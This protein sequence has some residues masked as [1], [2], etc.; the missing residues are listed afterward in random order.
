MSKINIFCIKK[1]YLD[2]KFPAFS[3][4]EI[5]VAE[6]IGFETVTNDYSSTVTN[7]KATMKEIISLKME[8]LED[9]DRLTQVRLTKVKQTLIFRKNILTP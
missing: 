5:I 8:R 2:I 6:E 7:L 9:R 1:N 3:E 4:D